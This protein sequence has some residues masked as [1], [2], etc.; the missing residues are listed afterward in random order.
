M[1]ELAAFLAACYDEAEALAKAVLEDPDYEAEWHEQSSGV[2]YV[3]PGGKAHP[4]DGLHPLG[5]SRLTRFIADR[6]P[7][8]ALAD[9]ALKRAILAMHATETRR[10][11]CRALEEDIVNG[12]PLWWYEDVHGCVL[13][14]WFDSA[15]GGCATVRLLGTEFAGRPGYREEW[16][17]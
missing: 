7:A 14:G 11:Q 2:L 10:E 8:R 16:K 5:D 17:P 13:C 12:K 3:G 4:L 15:A 1:D 9:I 6:D